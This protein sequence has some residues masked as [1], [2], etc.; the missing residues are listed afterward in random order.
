[1]ARGALLPPA[2]WPAGALGPCG[3]LGPLGVTPEDWLDL[4]DPDDPDDPDD[5]PRSTMNVT[6]AITTT[7]AITDTATRG[8]S[9]GACVLWRD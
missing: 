8:S 3:M 4:S 6:T 5:P 7:V 9:I 2:N 1:M